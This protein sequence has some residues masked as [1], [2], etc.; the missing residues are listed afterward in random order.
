VA[1]D[2]GLGAGPS[3]ASV[4]PARE[5]RAT[6]ATATVRK[7]LLGAMVLAPR[8]RNAADAS[9]FCVLKARNRGLDSWCVCVVLCVF[10]RDERR[11]LFIAL[12][13]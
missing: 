11:L 3:A 1:P 6:V 13:R 12:M 4:T 2:V 5:E 7:I 9:W 10:W 8:E